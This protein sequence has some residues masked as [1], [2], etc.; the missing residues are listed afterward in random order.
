[1]KNGVFDWQTGTLQEHSPEYEFITQIPIEYKE[2]AECPNIDRF[3]LST[4]PPDCIKLAKEI[5]GYCLLP[6]NR[7]QRAFMLIGTG[8][9]GKGTFI[10]LLEAFL[11]RENISTIPLQELDNHKFKRAELFGKLANVFSDLDRKAL[12][13]TSYFKT[14]VAGDS[15]DAERKYGG[16]FFFRPYAKLVFSANEIP[17][18]PDNTHAFHR[19]WCII[20]FNN[21]FEGANEDVEILKKLTTPEELSGLLNAALQGLVGLADNNGFTE[22]KT[23]IET[24]DDYRRASDSA[25]AFLSENT[26][27]GPEKYV[28][29][30]NI[31]E[32]Y[33]EWCEKVGL[34]KLSNTKFNSRL[35]ESFTV[36]DTLKRDV[37]KIWQGIGLINEENSEF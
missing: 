8:A 11:G 1:L 27:A 34:L 15:I 13:G 23:V 10:N 7:F 9:N 29:K 31:Y 19:R 5:F 35:K 30:A 33:K 14:V 12:K 22:P 18:S 3:F 37:G 21:K 26:V 32:K 24:K 4:L 36:Q 6:D 25:Y 20:P 16:P 2:N 28:K 17:H